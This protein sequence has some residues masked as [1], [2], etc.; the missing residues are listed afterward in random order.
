MSKGGE[1]NLGFQRKKLL[2][3]LAELEEVQ[4][5]RTLTDD[6]SAKKSN[7]MLQYEELIKKEEISWRQKSKAL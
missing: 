6:E 1:G 5:V 3:Q 7:F 4:E 2:R